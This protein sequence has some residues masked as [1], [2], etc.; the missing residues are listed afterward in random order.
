MRDWKQELY[1]VVVAVLVFYMIIGKRKLV[2]LEDNLDD[3][4]LVDPLILQAL[5]MQRRLNE[6][7]LRISEATMRNERLFIRIR[8]WERETIK[9]CCKSTLY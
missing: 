1:I 2:E 3:E 9:D 4:I 8:D 5:E 6:L 7:N